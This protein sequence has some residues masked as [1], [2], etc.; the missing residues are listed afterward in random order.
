MINRVRECFQSEYKPTVYAR[1]NAVHA[2]LDFNTTADLNV[3]RTPYNIYVYICTYRRTSGRQRWFS[4]V[5]RK[6]CLAPKPSLRSCERLLAPPAY[7]K[8]HSLIRRRHVRTAKSKWVRR[9]RAPSRTGNRR[10]RLFRL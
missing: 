2:G 1:A 4:C 5:L 6:V 8:R 3:I 9:D 10:S 7:R